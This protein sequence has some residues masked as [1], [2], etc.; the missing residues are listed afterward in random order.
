MDKLSLIILLAFFNSSIAIAD[1]CTLTV[2]SQS[3]LTLRKE[4]N[5]KSEKIAIAKF[6]EI[7][8]TYGDCDFSH[9]NSKLVEI[10][11]IKGYWLEVWYNEQQGYMFSGYLVIGD[12]FPNSRTDTLDLV[13]MDKII[14]F[15]DDDGTYH[16][17]SFNYLS[18]DPKLNWYGVKIDKEYT[19]LEKTTI[20]PIFDNDRWQKHG[21][22]RNGDV[23][24]SI[25]N[26]ENYSFL[27]GTKN[28]LGNDKFESTIH[29][30]CDGELGIFL[31]PEQKLSIEFKNKNYAFIAREKYTI[32]NHQ[33]N[34]IEKKYDLSLY[35]FEDEVKIINKENILNLWGSA[36]ICANYKNPKLLWSSDLNRDGYLD[37]IFIVSPMKDAC[38]AFPYL[39][40]IYSNIN[41][42]GKLFYCSNED[43][44]DLDNIIT[45]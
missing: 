13:I 3:G 18:Y 33:E 26:W 8:F 28:S 5:L 20:Q 17:D 29:K 7:V 35:I 41:E 32:V 37:F 25:T 15:R 19:L 12:I 39:R 1:M 44:F 30:N 14:R 42:K 40:F 45:E 10:D 21:L 27:I 2:V 31:F 9:L 23:F 11:G 34:Q 38:G 6:G 4:P 24:L 16:V 22:N 36:M 43:V